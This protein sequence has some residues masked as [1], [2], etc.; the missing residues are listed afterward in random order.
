MVDDT[1][2]TAELVGRVPALHT[3][4]SDACRTRFRWHADGW[5]PDHDS[6]GCD[7][8]GWRFH[9]HG[10]CHRCRHDDGSW[11]WRGLLGRGLL[12]LRW[13]LGHRLF[14]LRGFLRHRLCG[15]LGFFWR[16]SKDQGGDEAS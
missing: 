8:H 16:G 9:D 12:G 10:R 11:W 7:H 3:A 6:W 14:G 13:F 5:R 15:F 2:A 1:S 4:E